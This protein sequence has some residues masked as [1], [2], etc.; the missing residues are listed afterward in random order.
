MQPRDKYKA[1]VP[2]VHRILLEHWDPIGV[3]EAPEAQDEYDSYVPGVI[4]LLIN[5]S[6]AETIAAHLGR[7]VVE[8]IG[9]RPNLERDMNVADQ[10]LSAAKDRL[11]GGGW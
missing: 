9:L 2:I 10:L 5:G 8:M 7:I 11:E 6:P 3:N 4:A 1:L